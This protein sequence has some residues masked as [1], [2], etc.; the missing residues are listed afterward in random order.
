[1]IITSISNIRKTM[2]IVSITTQSLV[3]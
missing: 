1:M 3:L 2:L